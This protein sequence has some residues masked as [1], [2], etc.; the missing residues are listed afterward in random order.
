MHPDSQCETSLVSVAIQPQVQNE[1]SSH[2]GCLQMTAPGP[3]SSGGPSAPSPISLLVLGRPGPAIRHW[4]RTIA[5]HR[6]G[7]HL[8]L[9]KEIGHS[10]VDSREARPG[11]AVVADC[12]HGNT[13]PWGAPGCLAPQVPRGLRRVGE[14]CTA[15]A[16]P[17][18]F[19][20][21]KTRRG[22]SLGGQTPRSSASLV[23][24]Q[25]YEHNC[26]QHAALD[27]KHFYLTKKN[28]G[29]VGGS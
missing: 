28:G 17:V 27:K 16:Q 29:G 4:N 11:F 20:Q 13:C 9:A 24:L 26:G 6:P 2:T 22:K 12:S 25:L 10:Q 5:M 1:H 3:D 18:P 21:G 7:C 19:L 8:R 15:G 14:G 23:P